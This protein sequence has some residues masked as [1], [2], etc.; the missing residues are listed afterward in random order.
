MI[1]LTITP[2]QAEPF[3]KQMQRHEWEMV[4]Q[5]GGQSQFIGWAYV[6]HW[7]KEIDDKMAKVWLHYSD[8]QGQLEAYLEMNPAAKPL[9]DQIVAEISEE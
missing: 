5:E 7:Q 1:Y 8:N 4:S 3:Q 2:S 6:M 9:I